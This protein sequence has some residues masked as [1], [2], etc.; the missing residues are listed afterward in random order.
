MTL[1]N[2][3]VRKYFEINSS[4]SAKIYVSFS[5]ACVVSAYRIVFLS[6]R[7]PLCFFLLC[8]ICHCALLWHHFLP[9]PHQVILPT[10]LSLWVL[11]FA[12]FFLEKLCQSSACCC[13]C[14]VWSCFSCHCMCSCCI[15]LATIIPFFSLF[16]SFFFGHEYTG[17]EVIIVKWY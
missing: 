11:A 9:F 13:I 17:G 16:L 12:A 10:G 14:K 3:K 1:Y 6:S 7:I 5:F 2:N 8:A 4:V 15:P